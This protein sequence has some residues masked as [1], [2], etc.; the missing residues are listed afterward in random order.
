MRARRLSVLDEYVEDGEAAVLVQ[1]RV[2]VLSQLATFALALVSEGWTEVEDVARGL[3]DAFGTPPGD[4][5]GLESTRAAL[6][7]LASQELVELTIDN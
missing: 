5:T 4:D 2:V 1:D 7:T 6:E 3:V